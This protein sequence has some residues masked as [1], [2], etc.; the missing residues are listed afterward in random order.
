MMPQGRSDT[1]FEPPT[2]GRDPPMGTAGAGR[3]ADQAGRL[4]GAGGGDST[5]EREGAGELYRRIVEAVS[6]GI[7]AIDTDQRTIFINA[8]LA[9]RLGYR[10]EE[11][12]GR[13]AWDLVFP[14]D[15]PEG[16]RRWA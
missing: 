7:W 9:G 15:V 2:T 10:P 3:S 11:L 1:D 5:E 16:E 14:E 13:P 8:R 12:V 6:E 4:N